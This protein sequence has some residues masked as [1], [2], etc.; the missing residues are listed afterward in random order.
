MK[1][2][3]EVEAELAGKALVGTEILTFWDETAWV[4]CWVRRDIVAQ[5][6][7]ECKAVDSLLVTIAYEWI[8]HELHPES[9]PVPVPSPERVAEWRKRHAEAHPAAEIRK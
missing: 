5:G 8:L 9:E 1:T 4:A 2:K 7:T 6:D 3:L